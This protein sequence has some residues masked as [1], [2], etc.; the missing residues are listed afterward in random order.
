VA[1]FTHGHR[2][3]SLPQRYALIKLGMGVGFAGKD[4]VALM[5]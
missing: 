5:L 2:V 4:E 1:P 3:V